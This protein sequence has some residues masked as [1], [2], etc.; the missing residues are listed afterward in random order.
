MVTN[1]FVKRCHLSE[2]L[3]RMN[4]EGVCVKLVTRGINDFKRYGKELA[5][6]V[7]I[8][9]DEAIHAKLIV[10]D[11]RV[12]IVSSMNF[13]AGSSAGE[14]WEAGIATTNAPVVSSIVRS[15]REKFLSESTK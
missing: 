11:R 14:C 12:G 6:R 2:A 5:K 3:T 7:F 15:V 13:Y 8:T 1:P 4:K 10:V 9:Y